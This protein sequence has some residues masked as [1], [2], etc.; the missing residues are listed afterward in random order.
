[1][2]TENREKIWQDYL[3]AGGSDNKKVSPM[4]LN[5]NR[6]A[7]AAYIL[8]GLYRF[9]EPLSKLKILDFGCGVGDYGT[10]L[11]RAGAKQVDFFDFPRAVNFVGFRLEN[12]GLTN[13]KVIDADQQQVEWDYDLVI[14]GEVL[15]H[16]PDPAETISLAIGNRTRIIFTSSYPYRSEDPEERYWSNGDHSERARQLIPTC[17]RLLEEHYSFVKFE[18]ENR[19]WHAK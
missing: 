13:W 15:E 3:A 7:E 4:W 17:K 9:H 18:G 12:E 16:L 19:L 14:F 8:Q 1:M 10:F 5:Y 6:Y 11:L 2:M